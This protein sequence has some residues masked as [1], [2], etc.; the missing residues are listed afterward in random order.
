MKHTI[1]FFNAANKLK[2]P[3]AA[4]T[5]FLLVQCWTLMS[6]GII[7]NVMLFFLL[8]APRTESVCVNRGRGLL[9]ENTG[10]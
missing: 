5:F 8:S 6:M 1:F 2:N 10:F 3:Y 9:D 4:H 7:Y